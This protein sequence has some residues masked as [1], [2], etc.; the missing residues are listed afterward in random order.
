MLD[1]DI[2]GGP[3]GGEGQQVAVV[4][5]FNPCTDRI[6]GGQHMPVVQ[7]KEIDPQVDGEVARAVGQQGG[8]HLDLVHIP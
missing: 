2:Q 1:R 6:V 5:K 8:R 3:V 7:H 4:R